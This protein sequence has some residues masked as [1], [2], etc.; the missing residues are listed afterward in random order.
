VRF[1]KLDFEFG[2]TDCSLVTFEV[3]PRFVEKQTT[4]RQAAAEFALRKETALRPGR[5]IPISMGLGCQE[6]T[7][8]MHPDLAKFDW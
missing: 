7:P 2:P 4:L 1:P 3:L 8:P 5:R 6:R